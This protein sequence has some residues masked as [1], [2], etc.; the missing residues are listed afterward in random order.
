[1]R[2]T[3]AASSPPVSS[4]SFSI[5]PR[6]PATTISPRVPPRVSSRRIV[7]MPASGGSMSMPA[8]SMIF[9]IDPR[10]AMPMPPHAVQSITIARVS[11]RVRA[12]VARE[13]AQQIVGRAVIGLSGIAEASRRLN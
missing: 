3:L 11:G 12:Q 13:L 4:N 7:G 10:V 2:L 6:R 5:R 9:G 8:A 1:M